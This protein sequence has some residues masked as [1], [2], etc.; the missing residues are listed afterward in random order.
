MHE[1]EESPYEYES[2]EDSTEGAHDVEDEEWVALSVEG[3]TRVLTP[4][5]KQCCAAHCLKGRE[6]LL[7]LFLHSCQWLGQ[8]AFASCYNVGD[9]TLTR[10]APLRALKDHNCRCL[11]LD[12]VWT[13]IAIE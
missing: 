10:Y 3:R 11:T 4:V 8:S 6:A 5:E 7:E 9:A 1:D 12:F 2:D 13:D